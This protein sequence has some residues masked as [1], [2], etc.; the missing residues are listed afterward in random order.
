MGILRGIYQSATDPLSNAVN[1]IYRPAIWISEQKADFRQLSTQ[2]VWEEQKRY[3]YMQQVPDI[4][5]IVLPN[6]INWLMDD[7][8]KNQ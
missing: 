7:W 4:K 8:W 6:I 2:N 3:E 1:K 5:E